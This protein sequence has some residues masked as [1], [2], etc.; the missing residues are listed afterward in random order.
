MTSGLAYGKRRTGGSLRF[1]SARR[2]VTTPPSIATLAEGVGILQNLDSLR[3]AQAVEFLRKLSEPGMRYMDGSL[4]YSAAFLGS[5]MTGQ[6][7]LPL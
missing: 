1:A 3:A 4:C 7:E 5:E 2:T 6:E